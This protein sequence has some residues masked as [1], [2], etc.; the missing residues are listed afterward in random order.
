MALA[1]G[2]MSLLGSSAAVAAVLSFGTFPGG[3]FGGQNCAD[4]QAASRAASTPVNAFN[5]TAGPNQ[6]FEFSGKTIYALGG[7]TCLDVASPNS[8]PTAGTLVD[9]YPCNGGPNQQ[10]TYKAGEIIN[11]SGLCLAATTGGNGTQLI[12][13]TC[14]GAASQQ[15]QIK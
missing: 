1:G 10:W 6:Q 12:V 15:W 8:M 13:N 11:A 5:C 4:V 9:S 14:S 7:Q 3:V 2:L